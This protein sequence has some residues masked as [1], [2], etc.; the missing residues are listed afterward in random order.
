V[1]QREAIVDI[2]THLRTLGLVQGLTRTQPLYYVGYPR[3]D[4]LEFPIVAISPV[5]GARTAMSM[6]GT[7]NRYLLRYQIDIYTDTDA[8]SSFETNNFLQNELVMYIGDMINA[9]FRDFSC[10]FRTASE[11]IDVYLTPV[12]LLPYSE[13]VD[14]YRGVMTLT[15][16]TNDPITP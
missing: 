11:S 7:G 9:A 16:E 5:G 4:P 1:N 13:E 15:V 6:G 3:S 14:L 2:I 12:R 8:I 10:T